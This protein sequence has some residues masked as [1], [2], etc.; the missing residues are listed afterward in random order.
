[1]F[2]LKRWSDK[3]HKSNIMARERAQAAD[4]LRARK[5]QSFKK[6]SYSAT[7]K[8]YERTAYGSLIKSEGEKYGRNNESGCGTELSEL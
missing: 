5:E 2:R 6:K 4:A 7:H 3:Q 1:M 8:P